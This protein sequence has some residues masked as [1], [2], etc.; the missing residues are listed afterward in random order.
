LIRFRKSLLFLAVMMVSGVVPAGSIAGA[1]AGATT[2][3]TAGATAATSGSPRMIWPT[4]GRITQ[5][6]GC[7]MFRMEPRH[8]SCPHFHGGIDIAN[9]RGTPIRAAAEGVIAR[10]GWDQWGTHAW[11]VIIKHANGV[12]TWYAHMRGKQING[13]KK[14]VRVRQGQ[15]IG[16]MDTTGMSTGVHLHWSV[17]KNGQYVN[18]GNY[19]QG[20]LRRSGDPNA[21]GTG[22][23][24]AAVWN[25]NQPGAAT[26]FVSIQDDGSGGAAPACTA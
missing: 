16:Y 9:K 11:M 22:V 6:Y 8:G 19:V 14:G 4:T 10:V 17:L 25:M 3:A 21:E 20:L 24:C 15:L 26:A 2:D 7:T 12:V 23:P 5:P 18:P 13:I 1:T